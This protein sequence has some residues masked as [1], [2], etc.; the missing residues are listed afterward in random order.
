MASSVL[1]LLTTQFPGQIYITIAQAGAAIGYKRQTC[2]NLIHTQQFPI[3]HRKVG[4]KTMVA[5]L[6]L[7]KFMGDDQPCVMPDVVQPDPP[8]HVGRPT[9][10]EERAKRLAQLNG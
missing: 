10:A 6:D 9:K 4:R 7:A 1:E 2:Y 5:L 8:R 3:P